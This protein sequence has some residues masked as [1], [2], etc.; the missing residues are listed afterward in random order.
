MALDASGWERV[1][2]GNRIVGSNPTPS[3]IREHKRLITQIFVT[4][5]GL[6]PSGCPSRLARVLFFYCQHR[7]GQRV[8]ILLPNCV[9][10]LPRNACRYAP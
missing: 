8:V 9:G 1:Y 3:A 2:T 4:T 7:V 6:C 10:S 5:L